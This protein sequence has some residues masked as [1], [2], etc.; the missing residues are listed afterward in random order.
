MKWY[1]IFAPLFAFVKSYTYVSDLNLDFYDGLWYEVY[2]DLFDETFQKGGKC[3]TAE[4][5]LFE[6]GTVG[7]LNKEIYLN[8]TEGSIQGTAYYDE[9]NSGGDLTVDLDGTPAPAPYWVIELGP[10]IDEEY[11]YAIV[12]DNLR[13]SLFVLARNID[14][15]FEE[16]DEDVLDSIEEMGFD[17]KYNMPILV[18]QT[19][20]TFR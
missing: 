10:I 19:K 15:F 7:V 13:V 18:D 4:Y 8:G 6:N 20:C 16:Y 12:S 1:Y 3:V 2:E 14:R 11:D 5:T 17:K 9:G